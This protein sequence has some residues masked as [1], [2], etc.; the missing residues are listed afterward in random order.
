MA[1]SVLEPGARQPLG[2]R[3]HVIGPSCSGKSTL[4][5]RLSRELNLPLVDLDALNWEPG[6]VA[7]H[8]ADPDEFTRRIGEAT[9]GDAWIVAGSYSGFSRRIFWRRL[10]SVIWLDLAL[11]TLLTRALARSWR[12][13]RTRE[14]LWGTNYERF[15][16]QLRFWSDDSLPRWIT[17]QHR[18]KRRDMLGWMA[19][20][21]WAHIRFFRLTTPAE[22]RQFTDTITAVTGTRAESGTVPD[23][24]PEAARDGVAR[25]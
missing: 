11:P 13:W 7:L 9:A 5:E 19:S 15:W 6:W 10:Q 16:P 1:R 14:L 8:E 23:H 4:A 21:E 24:R 20:R 18:R 22:V 3:V 17:T 25:S 2:Q 12:R